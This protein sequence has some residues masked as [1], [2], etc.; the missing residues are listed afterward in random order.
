MS[1]VLD[2]LAQHCSSTA[3]VTLMHYCGTAVLAANA[4]AGPTDTVLGAMARGEHLTTLAFSEPGSGGHFYFPISQLAH[5]REGMRLTAKK[6]F[7]TSAGEA[8][9]YVVST[10]SANATKPTDIDLFLV[11]KEA[12]G[13]SLAGEFDGLGM[14]GNSSGP[15]TLQGVPVGPEARIGDESSGFA[16]MLQVV[17][18]HFQIG[19]ASVAL[20]M[21]E[22]AFQKASAHVTARKYEHLGGTAMAELPRTQFIIGEMA[23]ELRSARAYLGDAIRRAVAGDPEAVLDILGVKARAADACVFVASRAMAVCGGTAYG[24]KGGL[25]RI[26]RDAQAPPVMAPAT[27]LLKEFLG[28]AALGLPLF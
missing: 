15:M 19:C 3:M 1:L 16:T 21:A 9:S 10:R 25:E 14:R 22:A 12:H 26:F 13:W 4:S 5:G 7:V 11:P 18:P 8:D 28:K 24:R 2:R 20:G 17:L 27:D 6:S 23:L